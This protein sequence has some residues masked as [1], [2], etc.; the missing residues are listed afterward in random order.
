MAVISSSAFFAIVSSV[1]FTKFDEPMGVPT[2]NSPSLTLPLCRS[3]SA[4]VMLVLAASEIGKSRM[5]LPIIDVKIF[6]F[7]FKNGTI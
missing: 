3:A 7:G 6:V 5:D 1:V 4:F 2:M